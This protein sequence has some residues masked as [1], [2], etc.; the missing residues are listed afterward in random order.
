MADLKLIGRRSRQLEIT[1]VV[2]LD[3]LAGLQIPD[4]RALQRMPRAVGYAAS[5]HLCR[6]LP[7][8]GD[9]DR[10]EKEKKQFFHAVS[11]I[12]WRMSFKAIRFIPVLMRAKVAI[13]SQHFIF[14]SLRNY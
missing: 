1:R 5:L 7:K 3:G 11:F 9:A 12:K 4:G 8:T 13:R 10:K 14:A 6:A 2:R